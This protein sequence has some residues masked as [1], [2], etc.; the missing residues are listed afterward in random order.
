MPPQ[1]APLF[2]EVWHAD[3]DPAVGRDQ[4]GQRPV[5]IVSIDGFNQNRSRFVFVVPVTSRE[6]RNPLHVQVNPSRGGLRQR[7]FAL[8]EMAR[9]ISIDRLQFRIGVIDQR[10]E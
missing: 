1:Q 8:C 4:A 5:I 9:S 7:S 6:R 10:S 3:L 2:G